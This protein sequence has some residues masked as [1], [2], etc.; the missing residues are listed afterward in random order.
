MRYLL[1]RKDVERPWLFERAREVQNAPDGYLDLWSREHYKSTWITFGLT[2]QDI[3]ASHG[4]DPCP[5]WNG[6]EPTF[7]IFSHNRPNAKAFLR[8]IKVEAEDNTFLK[9]LFP[10]VM[11]ENPKRDASKWS[12]DDGLVFKRKSN[13][14]ESTLEAWGVV[15]GQPTGKHFNVLIYDDVVTKEQTT[16]PEMINKTTEM[17]ELS[18]NLGTEGGR[19]RYIGTRYHFFDTYKTIMNRKAAIP[20]VH[21]ATEDGTFD[22]KTVMWTREWFE[23]RVRDMGT[24]TAAAQLLQNPGQ[25]AVGSFKR[26]WVRFHDMDSHIGHMTA[27]G[28]N[29]YLLCDPASEKKKNSDRT[30]IVVF[31]LGED[32]NFYVLDAIWDRLSLKE[33]TDAIF[34]LHRKWRP[35]EV[36]Y[37]KYGQQADIEHIQL[38]QELDN[39]RFN[40]IPLGG[41][42]GYMDRINRLNPLFSAGKI[43]LPKQLWR[44]DYEGNE[45]DLIEKFLNEEYDAFPVGHTDLLDIMSRIVDTDL[46]VIWPRVRDTEERWKTRRSARFESSRGRLNDRRWMGA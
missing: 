27:K 43:Y 26:D 10:D 2:L 5:T 32:G 41:K 25:D 3:L 45:F 19:N 38:V 46:G 30:A 36:G 44:T 11:W 12:E 23:K 18:L 39:Y 4:E 9:S 35:R 14:K 21:P 42:L 31:G 24:T 15:E 33:R 8:Q 7:G 6:I 29:R 17:W 34:T 22:G 16:S 20:R 40:I 28:M 37:E 1:R 13:P